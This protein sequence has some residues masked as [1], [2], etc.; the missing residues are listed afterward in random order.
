MTKTEDRISKYLSMLNMGMLFDELSDDYLKKAGVKDIIGG[1]PV[2]VNPGEDGELSTLSIAL[3]MARVIGGDANYPYADK[4]LEY[5]KH[6]CG[7]DAVK[8]M[9]SEGAKAADGEN[10]EIACMFFRA[11]LAVDPQSLT[12][13]FLYARACKEAYEREAQE[14]CEETGEKAKM[15]EEYIG[16]FKA[17][18]MESF[19]LLTILHPEFDMGYYFLGYAYLNLGLYTKA[20]ITWETFMKLHRDQ[21]AGSNAASENESVESTEEMKDE[22]IEDIEERLGLLNEPVVIEQGCNRIMSGD[23]QGGKAILEPYM[24]GSYS[25]WWPLYY[26][27]GMAETALGNTEDAIARYKQALVYSPSNTDIMAELI[28]LY[29]AIGDETGA[30]K[31]RKKIEIVSQN[32]ADETE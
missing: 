21:T 17:E 11:A 31:Y 23:Y 6:I 20:Q 19:E 9:V 2:P 32:I 29:Q 15:A 10:Y 28:G 7:E 12:A 26:Y 25:Q 24:E 18:S 16:N 14:S 4:Y 3:N 5:I 27:L 13:L 8:V 30:E 1:V 22:L